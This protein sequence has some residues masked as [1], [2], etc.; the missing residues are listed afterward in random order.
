M[1]GQMHSAVHDAAANTL[2]K[3]SGRGNTSIRSAVAWLQH[4][5]VEFRQSIWA[6]IPRIVELFKENNDSEAR[7]AG[8]NAFG[9]LAQQ[10]NMS[11]RTMFASLTSAAAEFRES[12]RAAIPQIAIFLTDENDDVHAEVAIAIGKL[13]EQGIAAEFQ[14]SILASI[15]RIA[16]DDRL[17]SKP[18]CGLNFQREGF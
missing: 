14:G 15:S 5:A 8:S 1:T 10:G 12:V 4:I 3:L 16:I 7:T 11:L 9:K 18:Q 2:A 6:S 13:S 17:L